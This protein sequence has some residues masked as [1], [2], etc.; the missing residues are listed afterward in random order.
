MED[1]TETGEMEEPENGVVT[2]P[3]H[4]PLV[5][6]PKEFVFWKTEIKTWRE[7]WNPEQKMGKVKFRT[8]VVRLEGPEYWQPHTS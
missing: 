8:G 4:S 5:I 2:Y 6:M 3:L 7:E 1:T